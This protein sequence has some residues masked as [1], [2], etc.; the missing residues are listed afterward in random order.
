MHLQTGTTKENAADK[1][2]HHT[3]NRGE[4]HYKA[5]ITQDTARAI[6]QSKGKGTAKQRAA[7]FGTT[8]AVVRGIDGGRNWKSVRT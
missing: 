1:I 8:C 2:L 3:D 6:L 5:S 7:E 4:A